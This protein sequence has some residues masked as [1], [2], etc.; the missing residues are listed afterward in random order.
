M[1]R[2]KKLVKVILSLILIISLSFNGTVF[3][4]ES[5]TLT[6]V[7]VNDVHGRLMEDDYEGAIGYAKMKTKVDELRAKDPN[8]LFLNAGD[9]FHGTTLVNVSRGEAMVRAMN[10]MDFDAM[11]PGNHDFNYGYDRLLELQEM[12]EF[13]LI[14]AN[15]VKQKD[16]STDFEPYELYTTSNG[17]KVGVFG[18]ATDE[19]KYKSHPDN[20]KGIEF[21]DIIEVSRQVVKELQK[22]KVDVIIALTHLG[23]DAASENTASLLA[24]KVAGID[25]IVDGHSHDEL[26]EGQMINDVLIVQAGAYTK[27]IGVVKIEFKDKKWDSS[28]AELIPYEEAKNSAPN[29]EILDVIEEMKAV[30]K[31][32]INTVIGTSA[33]E[34]DGLRENVRRRETNLGNL[35]SDAMRQSTGADLALINGGSIRASIAAGDIS[36]GDVLTAFPFTNTLAVIEV[37]GTELIAA[38]EHGVKDYPATAGQFPQVSGIKYEFNSANPVGEKIRSLMVG[39]EEVDLDKKYKMVTNDFIAAGGDGY[40]MFDGKAFVGEGG[41]L[42]DV[43]I[44]YVEEKTTVNPQVEGRI[45]ANQEPVDSES[46]REDKEYVVKSGDWLARIGKM[47]G[48][49]WPV[50]AHYNSLKNPHLIYPDQIIRIPQQIN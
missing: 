10:L 40:V 35:I 48:I 21:T 25:L 49:D 2:N 19:T 41:L 32:L 6:I 20:T 47:Y 16:K 42:S 11:V 23:I 22:E 45:I 30:N 39:Q 33:A 36:I 5:Q 44:E 14:A 43:L 15:I 37:T 46:S 29:Q 9:S 50:L 24:N 3:A 18:L 7:H 1:L 12:A 4:E 8:L 34:L 31:P 13:P 17:L 38:L 28:K 26:A 27:N